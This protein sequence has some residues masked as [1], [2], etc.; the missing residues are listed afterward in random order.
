M[1]SHSNFSSSVLSLSLSLSL[2]QIVNTTH[3]GDNLNKNQS[4]KLDQLVQ[5]E[6]LGRCPV[7]VGQ[8]I[9]HR[10]L[11]TNLAF[12]KLALTMPNYLLP[13]VKYVFIDHLVS[14]QHVQ[15]TFTK[16]SITQI[17]KQDVHFEKHKV[18]YQVC[19]SDEFCYFQLFGV[20]VAILIFTISISFVDS[21]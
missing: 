10:Q 6:Y 3:F 21:F 16:A 15:K 14:I 4:F 1:S 2:N 20:Q 5:V 18:Y 13:F 7:R 9:L 8:E 11:S 19:F 12:W 17:L